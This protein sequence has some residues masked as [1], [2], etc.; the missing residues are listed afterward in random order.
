MEAT[1]PEVA[2]KRHSLRGE[3]IRSRRR[4]GRGGGE[5]KVDSWRQVGLK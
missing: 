3:W 2:E 5:D 1:V 4:W